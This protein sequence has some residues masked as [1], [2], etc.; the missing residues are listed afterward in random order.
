MSSVPSSRTIFK[1]ARG[2]KLGQIVQDGLGAI[3]TGIVYLALEPVRQLALSVAEIIDSSL[4]GVAEFLGIIP[5]G[6]AGIIA[7]GAQESQNALV[8]QGLVAFGMAFGIV[9]VAGFVWAFGMNLTDSG[10]LIFYRIPVVG[11]LLTDEEEED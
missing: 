4:T 9:F 1:N 2:K 3:T 10:I 11:D 8:G 7:A 6:S 5:S